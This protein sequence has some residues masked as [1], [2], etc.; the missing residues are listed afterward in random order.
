MN[1]APAPY[2]RKML[3]SGRYDYFLDGVL[4]P[5]GE[6]WGL[7][8]G[9]DGLWLES[10]RRV[11]AAELSLTVSAEIREGKI[12][13]SF[14]RWCQG[15]QRVASALFKRS[16]D[17]HDYLHR[18]AG[19]GSRRHSFREANFF[20]LLRVFTGTVFSA[21][22]VCI[23]Q[24]SNDQ[25]G[26]SGGAALDVELFIPWIKDPAQT[27]QLLSPSVSQRQVRSCGAPLPSPPDARAPSSPIPTPQTLRCYAYLGDQYGEDTRFWLS[28]GLLQAYTW[29]Q[30]G[31]S[32]GGNWHVALAGM[33][34]TWPDEMFGR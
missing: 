16:A 10:E 26:I 33:T 6:D 34:G 8:E 9:I 22:P 19:A 13:R 27:S 12:A 5:I 1:D 29:R 7:Y 3:A 18:V 28:N 4:Q 32:T 25:T 23:D 14:I 20:P 31:Q 21:V 30:A 11:P 15:G 17:G 24:S 2:R